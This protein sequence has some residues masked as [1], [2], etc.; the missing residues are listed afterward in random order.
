[1]ALYDTRVVLKDRNF[2]QLL[3]GLRNKA[4]EPEIAEAWERVGNVYRAYL[5]KR[6]NTRSRNQG[7]GGVGPVWPP[8]K[9]ETIKQR[10]PAAFR[11]KKTKKKAVKKKAKKKA[12]KAKKP[13]KP[14]KPRKPTLSQR[15]KKAR[16]SVSTLRKTAKKK[17]KLFQATRKK[18]KKQKEIARK[19]SILRDTG[20][21]FAVFQPEIVNVRGVFETRDRLG[22]QVRFGGTGTK[23][24]VSLDKLLYWHH[25]GAGRLPPRTLIVGLDQATARTIARIFEGAM[26]KV[27]KR[28]G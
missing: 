27:V 3:A 20:A 18:K 5:R 14:R 17:V 8:L 4:N 1:M 25:T 11:T 23:E 12:T 22:I 24:G 9:L 16:K 7:R 6:F 13:L 19:L 26:R 10:R 2:Q 15:I 28:Q 21:M